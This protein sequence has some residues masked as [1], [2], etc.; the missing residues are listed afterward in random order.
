MRLRCCRSV[1]H[2]TQGQFSMK[3]IF[4]SEEDKFACDFSYRRVGLLYTCGATLHTHAK[5]IFL[6][7]TFF[8]CFANCGEGYHFDP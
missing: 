6:R 1:S 3:L 7:I 8:L 5:I 4:S 2:N